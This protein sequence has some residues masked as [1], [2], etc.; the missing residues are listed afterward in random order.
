[1]CPEC[2]HEMF[3]DAVGGH[4]RARINYDP[5]HFLL[6]QLDYAAFIDLYNDRICAF[7]VKDAEFNPDVD[8]S[9]ATSP[10]RPRLC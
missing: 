6:Q 8:G 4:A 5:S 2:A 3:L 9:A 10:E 7:H 1:M